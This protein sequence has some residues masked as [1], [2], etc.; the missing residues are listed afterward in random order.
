MNFSDDAW[1]KK[2]SFRSEDGTKVLLIEHLCVF[3]S[4]INQLRLQAM[5]IPE[6]EL[7]NIKNDDN[8][9]LLKKVVSK[10]FVGKEEFILGG[11]S[12]LDSLIVES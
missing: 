1:I 8:M 10:L 6:D 2:Y 11:K 3:K 9:T 12:Q 5:N 7:P 4:I